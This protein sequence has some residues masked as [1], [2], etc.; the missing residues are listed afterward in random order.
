M[1]D[2]ELPNYVDRR[3]WKYDPMTGEPLID[4]WPLYSC[5]PPKEWQGLTDVEIWNTNS[6]MTFVT[7]LGIHF[8]DLLNITRAIEAKLREKNFG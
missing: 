4:G 2:K 8:S 7:T 3:H 6:V 1:S 5:L